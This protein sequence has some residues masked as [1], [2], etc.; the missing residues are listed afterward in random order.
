VIREM[1][2]EGDVCGWEDAGAEKKRW[3]NRVNEDEDIKANKRYSKS[4]Q[5]STI[6]CKIASHPPSF[7]TCNISLPCSN[8]PMRST[9]Y[10]H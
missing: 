9:L 7:H 2:G 10:A 8:I 1:G 3:K 4:T 5:S 6:R